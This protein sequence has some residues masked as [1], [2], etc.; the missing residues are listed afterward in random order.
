[1]IQNLQNELTSCTDHTRRL[2]LLI[3]LSDQY[4][5]KGEHTQCALHAE[6]ALA[7]AESSGNQVNM[8]AALG[9]LAS[10]DIAVLLYDSAIEK[11]N[12]ALSIAYG[13]QDAHETGMALY[14]LSVIYYNLMNYDTSLEY[15][16]KS[17]IAFQDGGRQDDLVNVLNMQGVLDSAMHNVIGARNYFMEALQLVQETNNS[18]MHSL[19]LCNIADNYLIEKQYAEA[20]QFYLQA[21]EIAEASQLKAT[22]SLSLS[23]L[24]QIELQSGSLSQAAEYARR[25]L[26]FAREAQPY[27]IL[28]PALFLNA[29]VAIERDDADMA[30]SLLLESI[31][32]AHKADNL[33]YA[34]NS[35]RLLVSIYKNDQHYQE[36]LAHNEEV[37]KLVARISEK[38]RRKITAELRLRYDTEKRERELELH[39]LKNIELASARAEAEKANS[40]KSDFLTTMSHELRTPM[41]GVIGAAELLLNTPLAEDQQE[42]AHIIASSAQSLM[43]IIRDI[44]D[45]SKIEK[46]TIELEQIPFDLEEVIEQTFRQVTVSAARKQLEL[47]LD[48]PLSLPHLFTGDPTRIKEILVNLVSNAVKFTST[49]YVLLRVEYLSC[50]NKPAT[51]TLSVIDS[52]RGIP[53]DLQPVIFDIFTQAD[54]DSSFANSG[55]GLGLSI[56]HQLVEAMHGTIAVSSVPG[57]GATFSINLPLTPRQPC[58]EIPATLN[59]VRILVADTHSVCRTTVSE[60]CRLAGMHC[61]AV[62]TLPEVLEKVSQE[63]FDFAILN[64]NITN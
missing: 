26:S 13:I 52:G 28:H 4:R 34:L 33:N 19:V 25:G 37:D 49:G 1:M 10:C 48:Y 44:M 14:R 22:L 50:Q 5:M 56:T 60:G 11:N 36:A 43:D 51:I 42:F 23:G 21:L 3:A 62:S 7:L 54:N 46:G 15:L 30:C 20:R 57:N 55:S 39:R 17:K 59:A 53:L 41:N 64:R 38:D 24:G 61:T 31:E 12:R 2:E 32:L 40:A 47:I 58:I 27:D 35:E 8:A 45:I 9:L 6:Q 29:Q 63:K 16:L 18:Y